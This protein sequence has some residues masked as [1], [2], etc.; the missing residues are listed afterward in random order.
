M[1][2][3]DWAIEKFKGGLNCAQVVLGCYSEQF[4][5]KRELA[6]KIATGFGG[7]MRMGETCGAVTG[8]YLVLGLKY[9]IVS[10]SDP[11]RKARAYEKIVEFNHR[12]KSM[13]NTVRCKELLNCDLSTPAGKRLAEEQGLFDSIC[14]QLIQNAIIILEEML[15][16]E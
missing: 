15:T 13:N 4:E 1:E 10:G 8:A 16:E 5:L 2:K 9:G 6:F 3:A 12:F 11:D 7:G 14:P